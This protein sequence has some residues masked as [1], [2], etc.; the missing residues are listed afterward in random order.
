[1]MNT[2]LPVPAREEEAILLPRF[3]S[4]SSHIHV[5]TS[6]LPCACLSMSGGVARLRRHAPL[7]ILP[8]G[9]ACVMLLRSWAVGLTGG[10]WGGA[11][12]PRRIF[13]VA[14]GTAWAVV[15]LGEGAGR[16]SWRRTDPIPLHNGGPSGGRTEAFPLHRRPAAS[17][18]TWAFPLHW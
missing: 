11:A 9:G 8:W 17:A 18:R 1:M 2:T 5:T 7:L 3:S 10:R 4:V 13:V 6:S 16:P 14:W 12:V 15:S